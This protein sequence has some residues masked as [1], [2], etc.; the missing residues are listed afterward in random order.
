MQGG[1]GPAHPKLVCVPKHFAGYDIENFGN[2]SRLCNDVNITQQYLASYFTPSFRTA[3]QFAK[4]RGLMCSYNA[5][6]GVPSC[7]NSF[8]LQTLLR[9]TWGFGDG[10]VSSDC[11]AVYNVYNPHGYAANQTE[12]AADSL[13]AGTDIDCGTT[14]PYYLT[15][16][17]NAGMVSRTEIEVALTRLYSGLVEQGYFDGNDSY[18]R[19]L[20]WKDV[21]ETDAWNISYEAAVEGIVLLKN[22]GTLP[23]KDDC[24]SVAL[25]G[26]W[27]NATT[28]M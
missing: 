19:S 12:A 2:T 7:S 14:Y 17:F 24:K 18:Y 6:N 1:V 26:P 27:A 10:F 16:A 11:D 3:I 25:V 4:A 5:V 13:R 20:G 9:D 8:L 22:D 21:L 28:Q 23:L 15:P